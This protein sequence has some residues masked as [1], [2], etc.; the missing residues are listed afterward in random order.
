[1]T[2]STNAS[3]LIVPP[4]GALGNNWP[5]GANLPQGI[6]GSISMADWTVGNEGYAQQTFLGASIRNFSM[7]GGFGDT[8]SDL[9]VSLVPDEYNVSDT[10]GFGVG[11]DV[12]HNGKYD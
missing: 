11:D 5:S 8:S 3:H 1:M 7:K 9:N 2:H 4:T 6:H 12:Y 10:L